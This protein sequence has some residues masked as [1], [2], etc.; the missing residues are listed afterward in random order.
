[1]R[2]FWR[3][4]IWHPD[5]IPLDEWKYRNLKRV[6][7]P[8]YD[9]IAIA[10]G[11]QAIIFGST[12]LN[13]MFPPEI[14]DAFGIAMVLIATVCL[15]GVVF[16]RLW[17]VEIVG[18]VLLVGLIAGYVTTI[19]LFSDN[20]GPNLFVVGML[21]FGLPLAFFRL[22]LLGEEYKERRAEVPPE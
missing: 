17:R 8:V 21:S 12:L 22:S 15:F 2:A 1:M 9:A 7:L 19:L 6:W 11:V 5:A 10:A 14:V 20:P 16:P 13:R 4:T 18:K 3:E